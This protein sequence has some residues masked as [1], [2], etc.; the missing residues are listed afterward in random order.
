MEIIENNNEVVKPSK[1]NELLNSAE[2]QGMININVY[3]S[4]NNWESFETIN[5]SLPK[6]TTV[7]KLIDISKEKFKTDFFFDDIFSKELVLMLFKKKKQVPNYDYPPCNNQSNINEFD[8]NNFCL[9][10]KEKKNEEKEAE[11][12]SKNDE[13][14]EK[15]EKMT[16]RYLTSC[17]KNCCVF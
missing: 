9:V 4:I 10:E 5:L 12:E 14:E 6:T 15:E 16:E 1:I 7:E 13:K 11:K 8:K 3:Y 2:N 17:V